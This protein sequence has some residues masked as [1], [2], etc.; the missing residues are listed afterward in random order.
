MKDLYKRYTAAGPG[1]F[2]CPCCTPTSRARGGSKARNLIKRLA[3]RREL[4]AFNKYMET[5]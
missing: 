4:R 1:G 3:K 2:H 5:A